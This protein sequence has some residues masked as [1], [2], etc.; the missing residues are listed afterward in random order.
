MTITY[1]RPCPQCDY[2]ANNASSFHYHK[3]THELI[4][5]GKLCDHG[6][7]QLAIHRNTGGVYSCN[8]NSH[9]CPE[10]I[11]QHSI[12][13]QEQWKIA[14][15]SRRIQTKKIFEEQVVYNEDA[16]HKSRE[17]ISKR[18]IIKASDAKD[19]RSYAR[20][21]RKVAQ[22][23]AKENGH[24]ISRDTFHVD[25]RLS[26]VDAYNAKLDVAIASHPANLQILPA[27]DNSRKWGH[28]EIT[29]DQLLEEIEKYNG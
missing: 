5:V 4:P 12:R 25:H 23:W 10:Y 13:I 16:R 14:P 15:E 27:I 2:S 20:K 9:R 7:G 26:L 24:K 3:R 18:R 11:R 22:K 1:P 8:T 28:S 29:V 6:C 19:Y 17:S 21:C